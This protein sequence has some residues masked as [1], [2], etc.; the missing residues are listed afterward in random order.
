MELRGAGCEGCGEPLAADQRYC[1]NC[2]KRVGALR[3]PGA[4]AS[5]PVGASQG[6]PGTPAVAGRRRPLDLK[7]LRMPAPRSAGA[8][9]A[10]SLGFG[11]FVGLAM[12]PAFPGV[13]GA[14][15]RFVVQVPQTNGGG[16]TP[17]AGAS[18]APATATLGSPVGNVGG[19]PSGPA[20]PPG[21]A[22]VGTQISTQAPPPP[23]GPAP[24]GPAPSKRTGSHHGHHHPLPPPPTGST[25]DGTVAQ[26]NPLARSYA[27]ATTDG[28]LVAIHATDLPNPRQRVSVGVRELFNGTFAEHGKR[29][30]NGN[31]GNV[32]IDGIVTYRDAKAGVYTVSVDGAS[33]LVHLPDGAPAG[34][35]PLLNNEVSVAVTVEPPPPTKRTKRK[36]AA[37]KASDGCADQP[38]A[39][40]DPSS[41]LRQRSVTVEG[42][43]VGSVNVE[44]IVERACPSSGELAISADDIRESGSDITLASPDSIDLSLLELGKPIDATMQIGEDGSYTLTGV[45]SDDG[46][47]GA[48]DSSAGQGDQAAG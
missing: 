34:D 23:A 29:T 36:R 47:S 24:S 16:G 41:V 35:L 20:A 4:R 19:G 12:G 31:R 33:V 18:G 6:A 5:T 28:Q 38:I 27:V 17:T 11:V 46:T 32:N 39:G 10:L 48:N 37:T 45:S 40:P 13:G 1:L 15:S 3:V 14:A 8:I 42:P 9:A 22:G 26:V 21:G 25:V 30:E 44:G 7:A 43:P 2:G